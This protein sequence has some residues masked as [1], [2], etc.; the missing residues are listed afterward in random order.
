[1]EVKLKQVWRKVGDKYDFRVDTLYD[2]FMIENYPTEYEF[3]C[4]S[5]ESKNNKN[6]V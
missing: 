2:F 1:M 4:N 3:I 5:R 6:E